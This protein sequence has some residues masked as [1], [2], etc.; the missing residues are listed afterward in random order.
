MKT[1]DFEIQRAEQELERLKTQ[2]ADALAR[3]KRPEPQVRQEVHQ[4]KM[5]TFSELKNLTSA[6]VKANIVSAIRNGNPG[7]EKSPAYSQFLKAHQDYFSSKFFEERNGRS[8][9][10]ALPDPEYLMG[11]MRGIAQTYGL[12]IAITE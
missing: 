6:E 8:T 2:K 5:V 10:S 7:I 9:G 4:S 11:K 3:H 12:N 1:I